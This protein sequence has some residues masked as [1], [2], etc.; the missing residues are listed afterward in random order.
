MGAYIQGCESNFYVYRPWSHIVPR[1][2]Q[3]LAEQLKQEIIHLKQQNI[4]AD[5]VRETKLE[6]LRSHWCV[7]YTVWSHLC[8][9]ITPP[10]LC[11][12]RMSYRSQMRMWWTWTNAYLRIQC[13][14]TVFCIIFIVTVVTR[15]SMRVV[16]RMSYSA[17]LL[18]LK[19]AILLYCIRFICTHIASMWWSFPFTCVSMHILTA[20]ANAIFLLYSTNQG[21]SKETCAPCR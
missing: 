6:L 18:T 5:K 13:V 14:E 15:F 17:V 10:T 7:Q 9:L 11:T 4:L 21:T 20:I 2:S 1:C 3:N 19:Y 8:A 16:V 12:F